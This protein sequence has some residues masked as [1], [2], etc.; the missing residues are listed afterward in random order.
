MIN[1]NVIFLNFWQRYLFSFTYANFWF[2]GQNAGYDVLSSPIN[3]GMRD[4]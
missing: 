3:T 1:K 2:M 4:S